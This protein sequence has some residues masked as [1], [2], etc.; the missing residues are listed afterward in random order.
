M[1][2]IPHMDWDKNAGQ[3]CVDMRSGRSKNKSYSWQ[4]ILLTQGLDQ[5]VTVS[6]R[7]IP[8]QWKLE[9]CDLADG[10][11]VN[12]VEQSSYTYS[13]GEGEERQFRI[14]AKKK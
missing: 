13:P 4:L 1:L 9:L 12:M 6:W 7:K 2:F 3:Y 10:I 11:C 8:A 14:V 5:P